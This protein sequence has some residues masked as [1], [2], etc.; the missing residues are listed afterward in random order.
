MTGVQQSLGERIHL[1]ANEHTSLQSM[2]GDAGLCV[3]PQL[4]AFA[5]PQVPAQMSNEEAVHNLAPQVPAR[6]GQSTR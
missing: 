4:T 3:A 5:A 2:H 1:P 6:K